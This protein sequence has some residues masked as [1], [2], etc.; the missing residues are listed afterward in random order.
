ML[1]QQN[2]HPRTRCF[3]RQRKKI[4]PIQT[5]ISPRRPSNL[6]SRKQRHRT[7]QIGETSEK[8]HQRR[9]KQQHDTEPADGKLDAPHIERHF[10]RGNDQADQ[11]QPSCESVTTTSNQQIRPGRPRTAVRRQSGSH[12][13]S[14]H[15]L[16]CCEGWA[17]A[18]ALR[19]IEQTFE[20]CSRGSWR[21]SERIFGSVKYTGCGMKYPQ[22]PDLTPRVKHAV[23]G[24]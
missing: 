7:P 6:Q 12:A 18:L 22:P 5:P 19:P 9:Q 16:F 15:N 13:Q 23:P 3:P 10:G 21:S 8:S 14:L 1:E 4:S 17:T 2:S 11:S 24:H 20:C